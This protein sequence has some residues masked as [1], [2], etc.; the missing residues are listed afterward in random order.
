M[1]IEPYLAAVWRRKWLVLLTAV[2]AAIVAALGSR[3]ISPSYVARATVRVAQAQSDGVSSTSLSHIE[4]VMNTYAQ[5]LTSRAVVR[6]VAAALE[7]ELDPE[8]LMDAITVEVIPETELLEISVEYPD[9]RGAME[10]ANALA[11]SMVAEGYG[12]FFGGGGSAIDAVRAEL[13]ALDASLAEDRTALAVL[14]GQAEAQ[15]PVEPTLEASIQGLQR[16]IEN[17]EAMY[18]ELL[19]QSDRAELGQRLLATTISIVDPAVF[20]QESGRP[21]AV[22][23]ALLGA[24]L[25]LAGGIGLA[26]LGDRF[27]PHV[28]SIPQIE[29]LTGLA[30]VMAVPS[31]RLSH[32]QRREAVR[33]DRDH[34]QA[35]EA[36]RTL[37]RIVLSDAQAR[38][39]RSLLIASAEAGEGRSTIALNLAIS[40]AESGLRTIL[41]DADLRTPAL[42]QALGMSNS[43]GLTSVVRGECA[44]RDAVAESD[45]PGLRVLTAG[46]AV[47]APDR[48]ASSPRL[49]PVL[50]ELE[51]M[52]DFVLL[53]S[54]PVL[55]YADALE[56]VAVANRVLLVVAEDLSTKEQV[57]EAA[58]RLALTCSPTLGIVLNRARHARPGGLGSPVR[59]GRAAEG[60]A[61]AVMGAPLAARSGASLPSVSDANE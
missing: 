9:P 54:P 32:R 20:P 58:R 4:R 44:L 57:A 42:H 13:D 38:H 11:L 22:V 45:V 2:T 41:V 49:W 27:D 29:A 52:A 50:R 1:A 18:A 31:L 33:L 6:R 16:R 61:G 10:A 40:L 30:V 34:R 25:G 21:S 5:L 55:A 28:R 24:M 7:P 37:A 12:V 53:D 26:V 59:Q 19:A 47:P 43:P 15:D 14:R 39:A 56:L 51:S 3:A 46:P 8:R 48:V 35:W 23:S 60:G 36:H 17:R